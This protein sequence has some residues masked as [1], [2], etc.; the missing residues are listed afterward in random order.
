MLKKEF[1]DVIKL[2]FSLSILWILGISLYLMTFILKGTDFDLGGI[3]LVFY[4]LLILTTSFF[5]GISL[6]SKEIRNSG[7]EYLL[8]LPFSRTRL[9]LLKIVPRFVILIILYLVYMLI[10]L[11]STTDPFLFPPASFTALSF[12]FFFISASLS[13][14][15][16]NFV[17]NS[18]ITLFMLLFFLLAADITT[19]LV[20]IQH[21]GNS[22]SFKFGTFIIYDTSQFSSFSI[23]HLGFLL[24]SPFLVSLFYGF[25]KFDIRTPKK[26]IKRFLLILIPLIITGMIISYFILNLGINSLLN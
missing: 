17:G 22:E 13:V 23:A 1:K 7:L 21:F 4:Q 8:T 14:W 5:L 3:L 24:S 6:F 2:T 16:G 10:L 20:A 18:I 26:Y 9:L 11:L 12:S 25:K 19:W 15:R